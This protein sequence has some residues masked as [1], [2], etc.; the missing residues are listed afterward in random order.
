MQ[1]TLEQRIARARHCLQK[2]IR[3]Q[4]AQDAI[5]QHKRLRRLLKQ[6]RRPADGMV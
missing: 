3:E 4:R 2:A 6:Q 5:Q 1:K